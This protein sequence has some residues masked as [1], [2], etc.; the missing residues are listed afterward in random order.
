MILWATAII[1][2]GSEELKMYNGKSNGDCACSLYE[3]R[4]DHR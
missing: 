1:L 4:S 3:A 2:G